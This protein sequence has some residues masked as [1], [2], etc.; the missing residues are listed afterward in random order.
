MQEPVNAINPS[1]HGQ[2]PG[3]LDPEVD[4]L[5]KDLVKLL[6]LYNLI[7]AEETPDLELKTLQQLDSSFNDDSRIVCDFCECDIFQSFFECNR[8]TGGSSSSLIVCPGCY[9]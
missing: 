6:N 2:T 3:A 9:S 1:A 7:M 5:A 8:C 4:S